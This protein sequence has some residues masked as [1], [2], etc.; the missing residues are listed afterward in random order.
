M[1][2]QAALWPLC[3]RLTGAQCAASRS[4]D[5]REVSRRQ[6]EVGWRLQVS[7]EL[8]ELLPFPI[9]T[10][11]SAENSPRD[12]SFTKWARNSPKK[13]NHLHREKRRKGER[14]ITPI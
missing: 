5:T 11:A 3:A 6:A 8:R 14:S 9:R 13:E 10:E 2:P 1:L 7:H 4:H 12:A